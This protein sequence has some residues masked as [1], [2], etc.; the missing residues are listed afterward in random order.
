MFN[1]AYDEVTS[2]PGR[3]AH[4]C[5]CY[6]YEHVTCYPNFVTMFAIKLY[7]CFLYKKGDEANEHNN[8]A[9]QTDHRAQ[10]ILIYIRGQSEI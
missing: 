6:N 7:V 8:I 5:M 9:T 4:T 3:Y 2:I 1:I 10:H